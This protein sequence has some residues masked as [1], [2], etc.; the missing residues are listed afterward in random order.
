MREL[1]RP[2]GGR[3]HAQHGKR[4]KLLWNKYAKRKAD[5]RQKGEEMYLLSVL[6]V[7]VLFLLYCI[8]V[9]GFQFHFLFWFVD[10]PALTV[11][12]ISPVPFLMLS[13]LWGDF[14][15]AFRLAGKRKEAESLM[16][17]KRAK[18][19][20]KLAKNTVLGFAAFLAFVQ[21]LLALHLFDD[22]H[23]LGYLLVPIALSMVYGMA[24][25]L[26]LQPL[27]AALELRILELEEGSVKNN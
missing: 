20:I 10:L 19:A 3:Y 13:G 1:G 4:M 18:E 27:Q 12:L 6:A 15:R 16:E 24:A 23:S 2:G 21:G 5:F 22:F 26:V 11:V 17:L 14:V 7:F 25:V 9:V 8:W